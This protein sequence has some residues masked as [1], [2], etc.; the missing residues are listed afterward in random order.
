M[1][2]MSDEEAPVEQAAIAGIGTKVF[3]KWDAT[4]VVCSDPGI[5]PTSTSQPSEHHTAG[6]ARKSL[7]RQGQAVH[8]REV[9]QQPDEDGKYAGKKQ[10]CA[11]AF[12]A[13]LDSMA[14]RK[15][16]NPLQLFIDAVVNSAPCEEITRIKFGAVSQPKAVDSSPSRRLD[17]ALRNL[18]KG[19]AAATAKS[20]RT[21]TQGIISELSKA[22][23]G[24]IASFAVSK[25]EEIERIAASAR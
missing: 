14:E 1:M 5:A 20:T 17:T 10:H 13:A 9:H 7:L 4:E 18:A 2:P 21:L 15:G 19:C 23:D 16:E 12:E 3:G 22:S 6:Q 11:K 24:D 25:R 8:H